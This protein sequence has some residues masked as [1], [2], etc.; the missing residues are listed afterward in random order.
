VSAD[1][2]AVCPRCLA[3]ERAAAEELAVLAAE[4]YGKVPVEE[5]QA[6]NAT[7]LEA[8]PDPE[9]FGTFREDYEFYG[10]GE[11]EVVAVYKGECQTCGLAVD[12]RHEHPFYSGEE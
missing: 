12:F 9:A 1:N 3:R 10:A 11:G 8:I 2:W 4:A 7:A 6:M 5:W